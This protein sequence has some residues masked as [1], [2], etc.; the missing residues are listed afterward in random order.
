LFLPSITEQ[1]GYFLPQNC[2]G[3]TRCGHPSLYWL[4]IEIWPIVA[5]PPQGSKFDDQKPRKALICG[6]SEK[7]IGVEYDIPHKR[8]WQDCRAILG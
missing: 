7:Q 4:A 1:K 5:P 6:I 8:I 3:S 2:L